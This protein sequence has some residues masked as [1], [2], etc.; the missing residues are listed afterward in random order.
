MWSGG[1]LFFLSLDVGCLDHDRSSDTK[2]ETRK[3]SQ[4]DKQIRQ[5]AKQYVGM[6]EK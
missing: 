1:V 6:R 3:L 2:S 5:I 4:S